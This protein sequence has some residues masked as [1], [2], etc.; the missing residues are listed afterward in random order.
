MSPAATSCDSRDG[1]KGASAGPGAATGFFGAGTSL[2]LTRSHRRTWSRVSTIARSRPEPQST[3]SRN[4]SRDTSRSRPGPPS[5]TSL[6]PPPDRRSLPRPPLIVSAAAVPC[7]RSACLVPRMSSRAPAVPAASQATTEIAKTATQIPFRAIPTIL[8]IERRQINRRRL[9]ERGCQLRAVAPE[10]IRSDPRRCVRDQPVE[11]AQAG[12]VAGPQKRLVRTVELRQRG[13]GCLRRH[14][15][16]GGQREEPRQ[17]SVADAWILQPCLVL[18]RRI[19][20]AIQHVRREQSR[21]RVV[22]VV[23]PIGVEPL[24]VADRARGRAALQD[25]AVH[26]LQRVEKALRER[27]HGARQITAGRRLQQT[28]FLLAPLLHEAHR[29]AWHAQADLEL[30]ADRQQVDERLQL[31]SQA[32]SD[33]LAVVAARV[34]VDAAADDDGGAWIPHRIRVTAS[35]PP[36]RPAPP[37]PPSRRPTLHCD[38]MNARCGSPTTPGARPGRERRSGRRPAGIRRRSA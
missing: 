15:P 21:P 11:P 34:E 2:R 10:V 16:E 37:R 17:K 14:L 13:E 3:R 6:P 8:R 25:E 18:D 12:L 23:L 36:P 4:P 28:D 24:G 30:R 5:S 1:S 35:T 31:L 33:H 20:K 32:G 26:L 29:I 9:R 19:G 22:T 38:G 27:A 7:R